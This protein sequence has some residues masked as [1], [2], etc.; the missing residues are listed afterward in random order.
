MRPH[1]DE[2]RQLIEEL[3]RKFKGKRY[4]TPELH[5]KLQLLRQSIVGLGPWEF[6][7][8]K[9]AGV[10]AEVVIDAGIWIASGK[11]YSLRLG[12]GLE[13]LPEYLVL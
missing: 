12:L 10:V 11:A 3:E 8:A 2:S 9:A 1:D 13:L 7:K 5:K 4:F 6:E